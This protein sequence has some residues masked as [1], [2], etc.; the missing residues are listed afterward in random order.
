V[1]DLVTAHRLGMGTAFVLSGK[2]PD[3]GVLARLDQEDWPD[4]ICDRPAALDL[5]DPDAQGD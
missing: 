1:A 2:H 5:P 4:I 3:H